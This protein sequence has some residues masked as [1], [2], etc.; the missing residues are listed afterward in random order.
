MK[1]GKTKKV[2]KEKVGGG[3]TEDQGRCE[4]GATS[5]TK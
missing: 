4:K 1:K 3:G 2:G 5:V